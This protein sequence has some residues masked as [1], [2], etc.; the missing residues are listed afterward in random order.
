VDVPR[1]VVPQEDAPTGGG[2]R[3][4]VLIAG[5]AAVLLLLVGGAFALKAYNSNGDDQAGDGPSSAPSAIGTWQKLKD[6]PSDDGF[7]GAGAVVV[8]GKLY[9]I[10]GYT[11][12]EPRSQVAD[13]YVYDIKNQTWAKGPQLPAPTSHMSVVVDN[14]KDIWVMGGWIKSGAT[15][16][17]WKL[18][19]GKTQ[20]E[21][22]PKLPE[23]RQGGAAVADSDGIMFA[24]G[25]A[26]NGRATDTIW[27]LGGAGWTALGQPLSDRRE[28]LTAASDGAGTVYFIGGV[29]QA[30]GNKTKDTVDVYVHQRSVVNNDL[31]LDHPREGASA[32]QLDGI[33]LCVF[34]GNEGGKVYDWWCET[35][36]KTPLM[37][38]QELPRSGMAVAVSGGT[39]YAVGGYN[40]PTHG[41]K[42]VEAF[43]YTSN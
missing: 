27:R 19:A 3:R 4:L 20:W 15:D 37:P 26:P 41:T 43:K 34:G 13:V 40:G 14:N 17:V 7:E 18:S 5:F 1:P 2:S 42:T 16:A 25:T 29:Q 33:G 22:G 39:I 11:A 24:G 21:E 30:D 8:N 38:K 35:A 32:V 12:D 36:S 6:V 31:K 9:V 28:K 23:G 10:G